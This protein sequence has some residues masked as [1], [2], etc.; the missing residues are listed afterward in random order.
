MTWGEVPAKNGRTISSTMAEITTVE[1][2]VI[3][4]TNQALIAT[5]VAIADDT[6]QIEM[7]DAG[8]AAY[9]VES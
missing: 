5:P 6:P 9:E 8:G 4:T 3:A 2:T 1:E 7:P